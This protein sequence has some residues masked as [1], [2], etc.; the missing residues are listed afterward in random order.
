M[1][2]TPQQKRRR[3]VYRKGRKIEVE[4]IDPGPPPRR[5]RRFVILTQGQTH[6]IYNSEKAST[7]KLML[8]LLHRAF[9]AGGKPFRLGNVGL[10]KLGIVDRRTKYRALSELEGFG[11]ISVSRKHGKSPVVTILGLPED[12]Q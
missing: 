3:F 10:V 4:T 12:L 6:R 5:R 8:G 7:I 2:H 9:K 1:M 11:L